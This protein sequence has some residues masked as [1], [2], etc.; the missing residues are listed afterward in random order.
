MLIHIVNCKQARNVMCSPLFCH[1]AK[2]LNRLVLRVYFCLSEYQKMLLCLNH[3]G[4]KHSRRCGYCTLL[5]LA[6]WFLTLLLSVKETL[7][8]RIGREI[9]FSTTNLPRC[10]EPVAH[11]RHA[12]ERGQHGGGGPLQDQEDPR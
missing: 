3:M 10:R 1:I 5:C 6:V 11:P 4:P 2:Q 9:T 7:H 12:S 8:T